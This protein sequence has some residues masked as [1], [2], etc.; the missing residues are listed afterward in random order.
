MKAYKGEGMQFSHWNYDHWYKTKGKVKVGDIVIRLWRHYCRT[1]TDNKLKGGFG[2]VMKIKNK[3]ALIHQPN[4]TE[5]WI[6][7]IH[8]NDAKRI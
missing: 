2:I 8:Y 1:I 4:G 6:P 5:V 3:K 7:E